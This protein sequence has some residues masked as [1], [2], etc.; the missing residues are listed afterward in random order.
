MVDVWR[1][2]LT[3]ATVCSWLSVCL[4]YGLQCYKFLVSVF[5]NLPSNSLL[6]KRWPL[7]SSYFNEASEGLRLIHHR[8]R[9]RGFKLA[10]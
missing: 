6:D 3:S 10:W 2:G 8:W 9:V 4:L 7:C 1:L 5:H